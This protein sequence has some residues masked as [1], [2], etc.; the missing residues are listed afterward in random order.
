MD[1]GT[2]AEL[3]KAL[4]GDSKQCTA[5]IMTLA[6]IGDVSLL[7]QLLMANTVR[8]ANVFNVENSGYKVQKALYQLA[9]KDRDTAIP[10]LAAGLNSERLEVREVASGVLVMLN[11]TPMNI[12]PISEASDG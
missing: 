8:P 10:V 12:T 7:G 4:A 2:K 5:A 1:K 11:E 9:M 6:G 3:M